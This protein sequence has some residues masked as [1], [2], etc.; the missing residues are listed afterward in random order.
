MALRSF[1]DDD[2][3][4][5]PLGLLNACTNSTFS[6]QNYLGLLNTDALLGIAN[7]AHVAGCKNIRGWKCPWVEVSGGGSVRGWKCPGW[8]CPWVELSAGGS[9]LGGNVRGGSVRGWKCPGWKCPW[10]EVSGV[11]VS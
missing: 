2:E 6:C 9:V 5:N 11:E 8:K 4:R 10:V 7:R 3:R 1:W